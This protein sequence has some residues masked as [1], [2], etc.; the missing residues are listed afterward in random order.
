M[1]KCNAYFSGFFGIWGK[2]PGG[3]SN[4]QGKNRK[5]QTT[6]YS[7]VF[8]W[9]PQSDQVSSKLERW[10]VSPQ[11]GPLVDSVLNVTTFDESKR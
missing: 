10:H 8:E 2:K 6:L 7:R 5:N 4:S 11:P 9:F 3:W 1:S